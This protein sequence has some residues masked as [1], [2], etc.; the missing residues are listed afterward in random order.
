MYPFDQV[1]TSEVFSGYKFTFG[2]VR[3]SEIFDHTIVR[4]WSRG[5]VRYN[6]GFRHLLGG[7]ALY[8]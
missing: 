4:Y 6:K 5:V 3:I 8:Q 1:H 7:N 2:G